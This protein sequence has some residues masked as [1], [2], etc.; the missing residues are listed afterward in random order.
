MLAIIFLILTVGN[1]L[2][3]LRHPGNKKVKIFDEKL[4]TEN[5]DVYIEF[6]D[7]FGMLYNSNIPLM[8]ERAMASANGGPGRIVAAKSI[9]FRKPARLGDKLEVVVKHP[10]QP[11]CETFGIKIGASRSFGGLPSNIQALSHIGADS[12]HLQDDWSEEIASGTGI[13]FCK[14]RYFQT[15]GSSDPQYQGGMVSTFRVWD[16]ELGPGGSLTTKTIFNLLERA[17]SDAVGGPKALAR[18]ASEAVHF[19]GW[20]PPSYDTMQFILN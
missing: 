7:A 16:D 15:A 9:K 20:F 3:S 11:N 19:Y 5:F 8:M 1:A 12:G 18:S 10:L 6:T 14:D 17:R 4:T 13:K 2:I